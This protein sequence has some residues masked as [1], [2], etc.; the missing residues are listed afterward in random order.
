MYVRFK[1]DGGSQSGDGAIIDGAY[2]EEGWMKRMDWHRRICGKLSIR[3]H[4]GGEAP[5]GANGS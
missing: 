4:Q 2:T 3:R 5:D 1:A